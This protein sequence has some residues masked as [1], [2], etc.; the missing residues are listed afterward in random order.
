MLG[1]CAGLADYLGVP[2]TLIRVVTLVS[3]FAGLFFITSVLYFV[4]AMFL[5]KRTLDS[6]PDASVKNLNDLLIDTEQ[7]LQ[8]SEQRLRKMEKYLTSETYSV[9]IRFRLL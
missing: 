9:R 2:V 4:L 5:D 6:E 8:S 1:V 3:L 7:G